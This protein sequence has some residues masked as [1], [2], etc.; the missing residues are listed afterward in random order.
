MVTGKSN[1]VH[2]LSTQMDKNGHIRALGLLFLQVLL[3]CEKKTLSWRFNLTVKKSLWIKSLICIWKGIFLRHEN[4]QRKQGWFDYKC[5]KLR[6]PSGVIILKMKMLPKQNTPYG[7]IFQH[8]LIWSS[9]QTKFLPNNKFLQG[10]GDLLELKSR[11]RDKF[12]KPMVFL[13]TWSILF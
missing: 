7:S 13:S 12:N 9:L 4:F 6:I 5:T 1:S 10:K 11:V 8:T 2:A 3:S